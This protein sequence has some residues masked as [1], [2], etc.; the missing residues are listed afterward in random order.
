[1]WFERGVALIA[2][3]LAVWSARI[4]GRHG[5]VRWRQS[6]GTSITFLELR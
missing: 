4:C 6:T 1:M 3:C 5:D 2:V